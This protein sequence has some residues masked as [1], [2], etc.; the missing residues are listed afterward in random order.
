MS[1]RSSI[2]ETMFSDEI[3]S[4]HAMSLA[5]NIYNMYQYSVATDVKVVC[6]QEQYKL[7][8]TVLIHGSQYFEKFLQEAAGKVIHEEARMTPTLTLEFSPPIEPSTFDIVIESLYTGRVKDINEDNIISLLHAYYHLEIN[9]AYETCVQ[10]MLRHLDM[11][12]CLTFWLAGKFCKSSKVQNKA[13][14]LM[15]RHLDTFYTTQEFLGLQSHTV[16]EILQQDALEVP[17]ENIVFQAA[18]AWIKYDQEERAGEISNVLD[19]VRLTYV[20]SFYLV[21]VVGKEDL[22]EHDN[23]AMVKYSKALKFKLANSH[24]DERQR[25]STVHAVKGTLEKV[26][27]Q[28]T[29]SSLVSS[30]EKGCF[31]GL[32][33]PK[34]TG[35]LEVVENV[36]ENESESDAHFES[37][38]D[39]EEDGVIK[40][41]NC[42]I[43]CKGK[44]VS[45]SP[46]KKADS[47]D[48]NSINEI[49]FQEDDDESNTHKEKSLVEV[50]EEDSQA[51]KEE[52][53]EKPKNIIQQFFDSLKK[54]DKPELESNDEAALTADTVEDCNGGDK[55]DTT[56]TTNEN[57][58]TISYKRLEGVPEECDEDL[59]EEPLTQ[60]E[61]KTGVS[62]SNSQEGEE[63]GTPASTSKTADDNLLQLE[64]DS[65]FIGEVNG[66]HLDETDELKQEDLMYLETPQD[67]QEDLI[68][69]EIPQ[70][71]GGKKEL[72]EVD[73]DSFC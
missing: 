37:N 45:T 38:D 11:D 60:C 57:P 35:V 1:L 4:I 33:A 56:T 58:F 24:G 21:N 68:N 40:D 52:K 41:S 5:S 14:G 20:P 42:F 18:M 50:P 8:S 44:I 62:Y 53:E 34:K 69:L 61:S 23:A 48:D 25:H 32:F 64:I 71:I 22:I 3:S 26:Q 43:S 67:K 55:E 9:Y 36:Q 16:I 46:K 66:E 28:Q 30:E 65:T 7:H 49:D 10:Y 51:Q 72:I 6:Q 31:A 12:N 27:K 70:N 17:D 2:Q 54:K 73:D 63:S 39:E 19:V 47:G 15:G 59:S 29:R 13:I